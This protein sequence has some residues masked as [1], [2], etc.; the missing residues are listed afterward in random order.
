M[1]KRNRSG[2]RTDPCGTPAVIGLHADSAFCIITRCLLSPVYL[3]IKLRDDLFT[4]YLT[5]L[6]NRPLC[7]TLSKALK[8]SRKIAYISLPLSNSEKNS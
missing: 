8:K 1:Y 4:P 3:A 5:N 7:Q 6:H 2:P